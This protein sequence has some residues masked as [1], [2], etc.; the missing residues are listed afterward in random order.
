MTVATT[1]LA[2]LPV[3]TSSGRGSDV[4]IP[5]AIPSFGGMLLGLIT[6]QTVPVLY[7]AKEE[8]RLRWDARRSHAR[9]RLR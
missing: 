2:L 4:M 6:V 5:M 1:I 7:C 8:L 9:K 3:L